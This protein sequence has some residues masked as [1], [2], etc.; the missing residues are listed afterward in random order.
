MKDKS[1]EITNGAE[2]ALYEPLFLTLAEMKNPIEVIREFFRTFSLHDT[3]ETLFQTFTSTICQD[4]DYFEEDENARENML[5]SLLE[6]KR[7]LEATY[8][9]SEGVGTQTQD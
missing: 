5:W 1:M 6:F 7:V 2:I 9:V 8:L 3:R 4:D